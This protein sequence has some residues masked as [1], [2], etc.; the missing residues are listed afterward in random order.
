MYTFKIVARELSG[1]N[2]TFD[3]VRSDGKIVRSGMARDYAAVDCEL[4][5]DFCKYG[6][7]TVRYHAERARRM[8]AA[9]K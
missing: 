7:T 4:L 2:E 3:V 9:R 1:S 6:W 5:N 8:A